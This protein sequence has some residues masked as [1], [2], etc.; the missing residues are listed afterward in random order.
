M[1]RAAFLAGAIFLTSAPISFA[2]SNADIQVAKEK[3]MAAFNSGN[4]QGVADQYAENAVLLPDRG[5]RLDGKVAIAEFWKGG[6][7]QLEKLKLTSMTVIPMGPET[8]AGI[9][10]WEVT[11]KGDKPQTFSGKDL[12]VYRRS[13]TDWVIVVDAW[14]ENK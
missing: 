4:A 2:Q 6:V 8:V 5:P 14:N 12:I 13:G 1:L 10:E 9:G 3:F 7:Q 11:T